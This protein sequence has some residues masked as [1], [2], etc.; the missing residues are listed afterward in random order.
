[1]T[2]YVG[3]IGYPVGHSVSPA[4]HQS[5]FD[6]YRLDI[7]YELWETEPSELGTMVER[8][9]RSDTLGCNVT[10]PHKET[11]IPLMD[12]LDDLALEVGA[13]NTIVNRDNRLI[14]YNTDAG[15]F[16]QALRKEG[17][18]DAEGKG[19]VLLGAGGVAR[20]AGFALAR[21]GVKSLIITDVIAERA[22]RLASDLERSLARTQ[23]PPPR[24]CLDAKDVGGIASLDF[25]MHPIP[26]I[27]A[28]LTD[29]PQFKQ[30]LSGCD[31]VVNCSPLGMKHSDT[32]GKSPLDA[33]LIPGGILVYDVVYNPLETRLLADAKKGGARTLSGLSMLVYQGAL[34][35]EMWTGKEAPVDIMYKAAKKAL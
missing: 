26:E 12:E 1:M 13:V 21:A 22:H 30:A 15:G 19:A 9:R 35:F 24:S 14:G 28:L 6:H 33:G 29:E 17:V 23:G 20:A 7:L 16:L 3:L 5:A 18:F 32:E 11:V 8:L 27:K 34:S 2:K 4:M 31:L 25:K 10:V